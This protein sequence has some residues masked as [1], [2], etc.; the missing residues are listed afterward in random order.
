M[1]ERTREEL[2]RLLAEAL[3][4]VEYYKRISKEAADSRLRE[5]EALS[6]LISRQKETEEALLR[7]DAILEAVSFAAEQ[8][9]RTRFFEGVMQKVLGRLGEATGVSR[10][11]V[12]RNGVEEDGAI[13]TSQVFEWVAPGIVPQLENPELQR[14]FYRRRGFASWEES[15]SRGEMV[16]GHV[17]GFPPGQQDI[18]ARQDIQSILVVPVFVGNQWWGFIGFDD[19]KVLRRWQGREVDALKAAA[20]IFGAAVQQDLDLQRMEAASRAKSEF[21]ANMSHELRTPLNHIIGFTQLI[22]DEKFGR[23]NRTQVEYL[24]DVLQS[25]NHLLS[26]INDVL[27]LSKVES[28]KMDMALDDIEIA[29]FLE[30]CM[31]MV[32]ERAMKHRIRVDLEVGPECAKVRADERKLKQIMYNLLSNAVKFTPD[33]GRVLLSADTLSRSTEK[34]RNGWGRTVYHQLEMLDPHTP[35]SFLQIS[36]ADNGIGI[37]PQDIHRIFHPFEQVDGSASRRY[38]GTG[39]GLSLT[40]RLV[41]LHG[42]EIWAESEGK[43]RGSVFRF[44]LP[45]V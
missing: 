5:A 39:L 15:L 42:G 29:P 19:C 25:G 27:D 37:D 30:N 16:V 32:K 40:K 34:D 20:D 28:G 45:L 12:F 8:F 9:L 35:Y 2:E 24:N 3:Q 22:L 13:H 43:G 44:I 6:A 11:Y 41:E 38:Q 1:T 26:L 7:R 36:V 18:L 14:F 31:L 33:G 21:L 4:A 23:V 10:V 17:K